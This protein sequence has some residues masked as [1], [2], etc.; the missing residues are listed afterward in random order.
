MGV[1]LFGVQRYVDGIA[2]IA[3][4]HDG[5]AARQL[6]AHVDRLVAHLL[7]GGV[8]LVVVLGVLTYA[9][10]ARIDGGFSVFG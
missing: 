5:G 2:D 10:L 1:V 6:A 9:I 4:L 7:A 3:R 8:L